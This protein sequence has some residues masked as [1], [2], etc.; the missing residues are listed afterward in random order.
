MHVLLAIKRLGIPLTSKEDS[1]III[2]LI[3]RNKNIR[4]LYSVSI[5]LLFMLLI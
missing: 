2:Y 5:L 4:H 1:V 3:Y